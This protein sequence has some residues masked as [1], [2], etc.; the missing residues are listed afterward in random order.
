MTTYSTLQGDTWDCIAY[1]LAGS[2]AFMIPLIHA[3][4][5][6]ADIVIF[7]AGFTLNVPDLPVDAPD[8]LPPWRLEEP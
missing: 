5:Q 4:P 3:N 7:S 1:K 2:E 6:H 8:S